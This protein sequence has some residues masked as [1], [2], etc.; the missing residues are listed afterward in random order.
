MAAG[1]NK[2]A[3]VRTRAFQQSDIEFFAGDTRI[4]LFTLQRVYKDSNTKSTSKSHILI[5]FTQMQ[6]SLIGC[7]ARQRRFVSIVG[8]QLGPPARNP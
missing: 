4:G 5:I 7:S 6:F 2:K 1:H 3:R 8:C